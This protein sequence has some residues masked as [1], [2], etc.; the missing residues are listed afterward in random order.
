MNKETAHE[1]LPLVQALADGKTIQ[2]RGHDMAGA[3]W[4]DDIDEFYFDIKPEN[5]RIKIKPRT[6][7]FWE[8]SLG[9]LY[10]I[11]DTPV[12]HWN[13]ITVQEVLK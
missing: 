10:P 1:Y 7:E 11:T 12:A 2:M 3:E 8:D 4:W 13:R 6:W 9:N 5:Y